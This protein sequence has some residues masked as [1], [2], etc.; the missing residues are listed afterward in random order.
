MDKTHLS[1]LLV[2]IIIYNYFSYLHKIYILY[3]KSIIIVIY[4]WAQQI[5][6]II[7]I[8]IKL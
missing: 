4:Y 6:I 8:Y 5:I 2:Y 7:I 3:L 1:L